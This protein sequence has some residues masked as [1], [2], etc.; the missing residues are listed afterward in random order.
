MSLRP[1]TSHGHGMP[2]A[3]SQPSGAVPGR[4]FLNSVGRLASKLWFLEDELAILPRLVPPGAT[5]VDVGA[6]RGT[7]MVALSFLA[8]ATGS[9]LAVEPQEGPLRTALA[10][11]RLLRLRN[12]TVRQVGLGDTEGALSLVV[13]RRFGLPVY[14]RSFL[15]D[16]PALTHAD[17][18]G[19]TSVRQRPIRVT[20]LDTLA[21][22]HRLSRL[23]FVKCDIEGA[24]LRMLAGGQTMI[25]RHRPTIL[26]EIEDRH[27]AKYGHRGEDV[28]QW[29]VRRDY[30][31]HVKDGDDLVRVDR[32]T[33]DT[34][35]YVFLPN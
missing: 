11:K 27:V 7:Y 30:R 28:V 4:D 26:L 17:L 33:E 5:C 16:A 3:P 31:A 19:F 15:A 24:E 18:S 14:G 8:G 12:V 9:V 34:R 10:L 13:P 1:P 23:D 29:L 35:N 2:H 32:V 20:T 25:E 21:S 6:N 22:E